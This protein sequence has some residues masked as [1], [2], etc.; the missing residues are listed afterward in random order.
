MIGSFGCRHVL[1]AVRV[2]GFSMAQRWI[3]RFSTIQF[4]DSTRIGGVLRLVGFIILTERVAAY[5]F[6]ETIDWIV[7]PPQSPQH[8]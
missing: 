3:I 2:F 7:I 5:C 6:P 1:L 4:H 8:N